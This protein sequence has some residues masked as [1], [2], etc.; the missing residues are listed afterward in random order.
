MA[1]VVDE[2]HCI[3]RALYQI[4][5]RNSKEEKTFF[6]QWNLSSWQKEKYTYK[7][8]LRIS[9]QCLMFI[10]K[11][12]CVCVCVC[13]C[14]QSLSHIG[15][16]VTLQTVVHQ[17]PLSMEF[18]SKN[19]GEGCHFLMQGIF[20][21]QGLNPCLSCLLCWQAD[22]LPLSQLGSPAKY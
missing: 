19:T 21:T 17:A 7:Y 13:V 18:S 20:L 9:A 5:M 2:E 1:H 12:L 22:S 8:K 6:L 14:T 3:R 10:C 4:L 15:L 16:F 11:V